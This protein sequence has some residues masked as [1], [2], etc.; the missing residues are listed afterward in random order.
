MQ[1]WLIASRIS[2]IGACSSAFSRCVE[3]LRLG[4]LIAGNGTTQHLPNKKNH[5]GI[6]QTSKS[7]SSVTSIVDN[8]IV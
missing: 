8:V 5:S 7:V 3:L 2:A 4:K 6:S 1:A